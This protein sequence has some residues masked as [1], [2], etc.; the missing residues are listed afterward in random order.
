MEVALNQAQL[1]G[2]SLDSQLTKLMLVAVVPTLAE[3]DLSYLVNPEELVLVLTS[4]LEVLIKLPAWIPR[5]PLCLLFEEVMHAGEE[6]GGRTTMN[7]GSNRSISDC[8][9][10]EDIIDFEELDALLI[11]PDLPYEKLECLGQCLKVLPC[12]MVFIHQVQQQRAQRCTCPSERIQRTIWAGTSRTGLV[13]SI[14]WNK[15]L[16]CLR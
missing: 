3:L 9:D 5:Q 11:I 12:S 7:L 13:M 16:T 6:E 4:L 1:V 14:E 10:S 2:I 15:K 8:F